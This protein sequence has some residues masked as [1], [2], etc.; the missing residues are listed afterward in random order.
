ML[1][2][3]FVPNKCW[4][5]VFHTIAYLLNKSPTN[6]IQTITPKEALSSK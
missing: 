4:V 6:S 2:N 3:K 5:E 1:E